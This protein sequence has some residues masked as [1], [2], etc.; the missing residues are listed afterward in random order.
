M[1]QIKKCEKCRTNEAS[2]RLLDDSGFISLCWFCY[3]DHIDRETNNS[4]PDPNLY[5][6]Q[7][8]RK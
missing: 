8:I 2:C 7:M 4:K 3:R 6:R 5:D 1:P